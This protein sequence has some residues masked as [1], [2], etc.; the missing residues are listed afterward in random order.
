M[1]GKVIQEG[2]TFDESQKIAKE[3]SSRLGITFIPPFDNED[4]IAGQG[5]VGMEIGRQ[6]RGKIHAIIVPIGGGGLAA[7]I[8]SFYKL[9]Y[10]EVIHIVS[11]TTPR[12][13][14]PTH[15][16]FNMS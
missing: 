11:F 14:L 9:V 3:I 16:F 2:E 15:Y 7:G 5:T 4:V 8:V 6:M 1:G 10:P 12:F 13:A